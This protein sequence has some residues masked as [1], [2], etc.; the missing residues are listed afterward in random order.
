MIESTIVTNKQITII[1]MIYVNY[2]Y[3]TKNLHFYNRPL[4]FHLFVASPYVTLR[5]EPSSYLTPYKPPLDP[6]SRSPNTSRNS[7]CTPDY[8][9]TAYLSV[10]PLSNFC[11]VF[12]HSRIQLSRHFWTGAVCQRRAPTKGNSYKALS[13]QVGTVFCGSL[14]FS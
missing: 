13:K 9:Y 3:Y 4:F 2:S 6:L 12:Y 1:L 7:P 14:Q 10:K 11:F 5:G 8:T